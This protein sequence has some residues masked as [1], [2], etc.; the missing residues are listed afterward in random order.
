M[1]SQKL[2]VM[3]F[4]IIRLSI[5][6]GIGF[7]ADS[8]QAEPKGGDAAMQQVL[9]KAQGVVRQ[10]TEEKAA[11]EKQK[12]ELENQKGG[13]EADKS[14][15]IAEKMALLNA[16]TSLEAR[17]K[18]LEVLPAELNRCKT[19]NQT[20]QQTK[21]TLETRLS[22]LRAREE[23]AIRKQREMM[24]KAVRIEGDNTLL[25][26]AVKERER[27]ITACGKRNQELVTSALELVGKYK[28]K[29]LWEEVGDAE[30]FTGIG[31]I[32][33]ENVAEEY[34]YKVE[35]LKS[36]PFESDIQ[37][38][39]GPSPAEEVAAPSSG[40]GSGGVAP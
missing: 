7:G 17:V 20:L 4:W 23:E 35:H 21:T 10:L 27:W 26:D 9:R 8:I 28:D 24:S 16:K 32:K 36:T 18:K 37:L 22:E 19:G 38:N 40:G 5:L 6:M 13:L 30:P 3:R 39:T 34:R 1:R 12:L 2:I 11:L 29:S 25:L 15:L 33:T 31:K 14:S